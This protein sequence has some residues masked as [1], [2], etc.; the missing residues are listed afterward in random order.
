MPGFA[1]TLVADLESGCAIAVLMNGPDEH[2]ATWDIARFAADLRRGLDP[3]PPGDP[4]PHPPDCPLVPELEEHAALYGRYRS[5][6]PWLPGFRIEQRESG[7]AA[8]MAWGDVK[9]LTPLSE[10]D[11]RVG[12][13][14]W[15][16]ERLCFDAV[17]EGRALRA[18]LSGETYYRSDFD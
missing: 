17:V 11:F 14:E 18:K 8:Q 16:P 9:P 3:T 10:A 12:E 13:E 6:N 15:S 2:D 5:Y 4:E 7:L 1:S